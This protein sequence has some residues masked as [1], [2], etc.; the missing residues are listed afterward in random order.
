[1]TTT[2]RLDALFSPKITLYW[3]GYFGKFVRGWYPDNILDRA[4]LRQFMAE[5]GVSRAFGNNITDENYDAVLA[6]AGAHGYSI[7]T[8]GDPETDTTRLGTYT[9]QRDPDVE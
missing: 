3:R 5:A 7:E 9:P 1:M 6:A 8:V 2:Q 4:L